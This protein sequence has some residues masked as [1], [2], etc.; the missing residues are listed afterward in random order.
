MVKGTDLKDTIFKRCFS[1]QENE[2]ILVISDDVDM[3]NCLEEEAEEIGASITNI[4]LHEKSRP[5]SGLP[6]PMRSAIRAA[7]VILTPF[8]RLSEESEFR[9]GIIDSVTNSNTR[10]AHMPGVTRDVFE[11]C[12][13]KMNFLECDQLSKMLAEAL[14][15]TRE[16]KLT[17]PSGTD[18][19]LNLGG[20]SRP[21][22]ADSGII[23]SPGT[24]DNLPSGEACIA[25]IE[26]LTNGTLVIDGS[27]L[28]T[29]VKESTEHVKL[30]I[31]GGRVKEIS[32]GE[33]AYTL[34][35]YLNNLD[36]VA[37]PEQKGNIYR[38]A[39]LGIGTNKAAR[40]IGNI[41]EDEK[42]YGTGHIALG[43]NRFL[44]GKLQ[45]G[46]HIDLVFHNP[47]L[48]VDGIR[49]IENGNMLPDMIRKRCTESYLSYKVDDIL[50]VSEVALAS[51]GPVCDS[52]VNG[53]CAWWKGP[54]GRAYLTNVGDTDSSRL[55]MKIYS[56]LMELGLTPENVTDISKKVNVDML[57][58]RQIIALLRE[59]C[60]VT[61]LNH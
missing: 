15:R 37:S 9:G 17:T 21:A 13:K 56:Y 47:T 2:A 44:G 46:D 36:N 59:Y 10:M 53:L 52:T 27:L 43:R 61:V 18:L 58:T 60:I 29:V 45:A 42:K 16:A 34:K 20:W 32:G 19:T 49:I 12:I 54:G 26:D 55:A 7:D 48:E 25:P 40:L 41:I 8:A 28:G 50:P 4:Y 30:R 11:N 5:Y 14:T 35:T 39:E 3:I 38:V 24:W 6:E 31:S 1:L 51:D 22:D 33:L 57:T 23:T